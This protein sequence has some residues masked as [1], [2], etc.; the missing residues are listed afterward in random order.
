MTN[1][2]LRTWIA[3]VVILLAAYAPALGGPPAD[4]PDAIAAKAFQL[5][6][7]GHVEKAVK[8]LEKGIADHPEAG[9]L[10]YELA[11]A[12]LFLLDIPGMQAEAEAA[13]K[14]DPDNNEYRYFAAMASGY[15]FIEAAHHDNRDRMD[16]M[17]T[18]VIGQLETIL[19]D[20]PDNHQARYYLVQQSVEMAPEIGLEVDD[21]EDHVRILE[22]KDPI[23]GAKARCCLVGEEEQREI[24]AKVLA[25][26]PEDCR[27]LSEAAD[28]L[29]TCGDLDEASGC[30]E[31]AIAKNKEACYG[32]LRLGLAYS[33]EKDWERATELTQAYLDLDP[34]VAL[35]A[36]ATGRLGMIH[37]QMGLSEKGRELMDQARALDPHVWQTVMPP[38]REIFTPI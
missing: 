11:R 18:Q 16:R 30:L 10:H 1:L 21:P 35:Q 31:K 36:Y 32:L 15:S 37:H 27:A 34:P 20:D 24:W 3:A 5:R 26:N 38:P 9:V 33:N 23:L 25:E 2:T 22:E 7:D 14:Y 8:T 29:I 4:Q 19:A 17:G 28:G 6:L 13:V 12:K